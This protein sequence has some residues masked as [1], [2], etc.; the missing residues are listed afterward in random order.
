MGQFIA[1]CVCGAFST[2]EK[3]WKYMLGLAAIPSAIQ[4]FGFIFMPES[5]RFLVS[6]G[7]IQEA[8][9]VL[10][11]IRRPDENPDLELQEIQNVVRSEMA[12]NNGQNVI[13]RAFMS[14]KTRRAIILGKL[15]TKCCKIS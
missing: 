2:T 12:I 4:F 14:A 5:P 11:K 15:K 3:G 7:K 9:K 10:H 13:K 6:K 1:A 8:R